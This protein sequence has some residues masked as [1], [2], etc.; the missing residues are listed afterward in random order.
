MNETL[1]LPLRQEV[2]RAF[3]SDPMSILRNDGNLWLGFAYYFL[4]ITDIEGNSIPFEPKPS[5]LR[6]LELYWANRRKWEAPFFIIVNKARQIGLSTLCSMIIL[7]EMLCRDNIGVKLISEIRGDSE[8]E[9]S[10]GNILRKYTDALRNFPL[11]AGKKS[12]FNGYTKGVGFTLARTNS[13]ISIS[14]QYREIRGITLNIIHCSEVGFFHDFAKFARPMMQ[15]SHR[16]PG[17]IVI[18]ES[19]SENAYDGFHRW[20]I[21]AQEGKSDFIPF[22][23]PWFEDPDYTEAMPGEG[24][25]NFEDSLG[26]DLRRYGDERDMLERYEGCSLENMKWR[27]WCIDTNF[28]GDL[29]GFRQEYPSDVQEAFMGQNTSVF[30]PRVLEWHKERA[31]E[32]LMKGQMVPQVRGRRADGTEP[33]E[34]VEDYLGQIEI[35][36]EPYPYAE[37][38]WGSDHA[39]NLP[40]GDFNVLCLFK[41]QP[42]ELV[43]KIRGSDTTKLDKVEFSKQLMYLARWYNM[44]MGLPES[45]NQGGTVIAMIQEWQYDEILMSHRDAFPDSSRKDYGYLMTADSKKFCI[46][47]LK[48]SLGVDF[49]VGDGIRT[50]KHAPWIRDSETIEELFHMLYTENGKIQAANKGKSRAPGANSAGYHDDLVIATAL[51]VVAHRSLPDPLTDEQMMIQTHGRYHERTQ[52]LEHVSVPG[53][54]EP[55]DEEVSGDSW[56][57]YY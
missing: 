16:I 3:Q 13:N 11:D 2:V 18:F 55:M 57:E 28:A 52:G 36:E 10:G 31:G 27:R 25:S 53:E 46:D 41:R 48:D 5:Q 8:D 19:T 14:S 47:M 33:A 23:S 24:K 22:F 9:A 15:S 50:S 29:A 4:K 42:F 45:N 26:S 56:E 43:A 51:A 37:Y 21:N 49:R 30:D 39:E 54:F 6:F 35:W 1:S 44:A 38:C 32:P 40:S 20:F 17:N 12:H 34:F 7:T